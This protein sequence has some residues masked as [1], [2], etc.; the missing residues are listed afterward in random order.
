MIEEQYLRAKKILTENK[1]KLSLLAEKLLESE[2]IFK[3]DLI[4]IFGKRIWE[5]EESKPEFVNP[6]DLNPTPEK[7]EENM[8]ESKE[9]PDSTD[10]S[11]AKPLPH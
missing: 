11:Q 7:T 5:K 6:E 4:A 10:S 8:P 3:D 9:N 1:D 2:V